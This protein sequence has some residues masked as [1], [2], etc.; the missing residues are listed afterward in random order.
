MDSLKKVAAHCYAA[1]NALASRS[2]ALPPE[3]CGIPETVPHATLPPAVLHNREPYFTAQTW[4]KQ[5]FPVRCAPG[6]LG[7]RHRAGAAV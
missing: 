5:P 3:L 6:S 7:G 2:P 4:R 1:G